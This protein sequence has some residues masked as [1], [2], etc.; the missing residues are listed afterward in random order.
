MDGWVHGLV[1]G[2]VVWLVG[3]YLVGI[4]PDGSV[5][6]WYNGLVDG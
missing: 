1:H 6:G 4:W 5:V 2:W 3:W